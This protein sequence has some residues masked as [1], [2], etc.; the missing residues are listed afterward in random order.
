MDLIGHC[1]SDVTVL[2]IHW[3]SSSI[4][5]KNVTIWKT[6][7]SGVEK[8]SLCKTCDKRL[9]QPIILTVHGF[10]PITPYIC[11][12]IEKKTFYVKIFYFIYSISLEKQTNFVFNYRCICSIHVEYSNRNDFKASLSKYSGKSNFNIHIRNNNDLVTGLLNS[13]M[14]TSSPDYTYPVIICHCQEN[15]FQEN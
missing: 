4:I 11:V 8:N 13:N 3:L 1:S 10:S 7:V 15:I 12:K 5:R 6:Q 2:C 14:H 9:K